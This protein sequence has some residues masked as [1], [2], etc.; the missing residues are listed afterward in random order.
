[1]TDTAPLHEL[2]AWLKRC[3]PPAPVKF[4]DGRFPG[5]LLSSRGNY[6]ELALGHETFG[7]VT[8]TAM[9]KD[10]SSAIGYE[11][12]GYK[13]GRYLMSRDTPIWRDNWGE[14]TETAIIGGRMLDGIATIIIQPNGERRWE[15]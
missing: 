11:F 13:G 5:S 9:A 2:I 10:L 4:S 12:D 8:A 3:P 7:Y 15:V 1:M 6:A 14:W